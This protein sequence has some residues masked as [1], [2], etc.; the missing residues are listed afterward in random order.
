MQLVNRARERPSTGEEISLECA[1]FAAQVFVTPQL[2]EYCAACPASEQIDRN[3]FDSDTV[4]LCCFVEQ[5]QGLLR[6]TT[7]S[8]RARESNECRRSNSRIRRPGELTRQFPGS[9]SIVRLVF[10]N[11][12]CLEPI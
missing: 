4:H 8:E 11:I 10:G 1:G 5:L 7:G 9:R 2:F 6:V 3:A 12:Q